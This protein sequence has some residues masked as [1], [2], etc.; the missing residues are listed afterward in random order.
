[1][2]ALPLVLMLLSPSAG[3]KAALLLGL[4]IGYLAT[5]RLV[6]LD[7]PRTLLRR[8]L[9]VLLAAAVTVSLILLLNA[10][11][12]RLQ[13]P[14]SQAVTLTEQTVMAALIVILTH[15]IAKVLLIRTVSSKSA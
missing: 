10:V 4:N 5:R 11:N 7:M 14:L 9:T 13:V 15:A 8:I 6:A 12:S 3:Q 2:L 1:M